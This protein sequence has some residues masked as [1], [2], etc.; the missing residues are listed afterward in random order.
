MLEAIVGLTALG[1]GLGIF[2]GIAAK[3]L[4]VESNPL[5]AD[6]EEILPGQNCGQC[7]YP[8]CAAAAT[9]IAKGEAP[10][11]IC[12]PG[13]RAVAHALAAKLC[14]SVDLSAIADAGPQ[15]AHVDEE[16]CIGCTKC[17]RKCPTD[18]I[19]GAA[20]QVHTVVADACTGCGACVDT[21]PVGGVE[22][23]AVPVTLQSWYWPKPGETP[24]A[25]GD[26]VLSQ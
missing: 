8:G 9:A 11:T 16:V 19:V 21:C 15:V 24:P 14:L 18:A 10:V 20:K 25:G 7:G 1:G 4:H 2:L 3:R 12:P 22:L 5:E 23:Q 6:I 26:G 17:A 13:G